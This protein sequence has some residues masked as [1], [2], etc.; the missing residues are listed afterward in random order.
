MRTFDAVALQQILADVLLAPIDDT[1][2]VSHISTDTRKIQ[3]GDTF[4]AISGEQFDGHDFTT[5]AVEKGATALWVE[6]E[7]AVNVPQIV[8]KDTRIALG[9]LAAVIR[10][11]FVQ[12]GG[13]VI[14]LTGSVGKTTNKQMLAAILSQIG[15]THA[16]KGNLNND[17][18]VPFTWFDLSADAQFAVIEMGA[19]H[20]GEI[21]YLTNITRPQVAMITNA[22]E[23]HLEGFGGLDGVAKGKGELFAH[24][25]ATDT[26]ILNIDD[27]YSDYWCGLMADEMSVWTFSLNNSAADVY[28]E[29][30][31]ANG[32]IF[33]LCH[34]EQRVAVN[35]PT[36]GRHNV[37]NAV[38]CAACALSLGVSLSAIAAGLSVFE[39]ATGRLQKHELAANQLAAKSL[40]VIDDT[41]N[42]NPTSMRAS[43]DIVA[44]SEGYRILVLGDMGE[45]GDDEIDLHRRLGQAIV[46]K[47][48][49]FFCLGQRMTAFVEQNAKAQHYSDTTALL[50]ALV[51]LITEKQPQQAVTVLVKGSRSMQMERI[52][53]HLLEKF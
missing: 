32:S 42:A 38:G 20:Q 22:G 3:L 2:Q 10:D 16:T 39:T 24:L 46:D 36:V 6:R 31:A 7:Q 47:A 29:D 40:T 45:L 23:A 18:G 5:A 4:V 12:Q 13:K 43:A 25:A 48:D 19:N 33:T 21:A 26:A 15:K 37:M 51:S 50:A 1:V 35:L 44:D 30:V 53:E 14:G 27:A 17:L 8:V 11:E 49:R 28:A 9:L 52:V 34:G 41:Y